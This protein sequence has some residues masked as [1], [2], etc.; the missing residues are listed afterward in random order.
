M[1]AGSAPLIART[2]DGRFEVSVAVARELAPV[3]LVAGTWICRDDSIG[4]TERGFLG[5]R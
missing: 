3:P 2:N 4:L 5:G 1:G